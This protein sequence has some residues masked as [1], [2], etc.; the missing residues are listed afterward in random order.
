MHLQVVHFFYSVV[1]HFESLTAVY[2]FI[3]VTIIVLLLHHSSMHMCI[4][5]CVC[6]YMCVCACVW[7]T[8]AK[9]S[10]A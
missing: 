6:V 10:E 1:K 5:L 3:I 9:E 2:K 7:C 8:D 4:C